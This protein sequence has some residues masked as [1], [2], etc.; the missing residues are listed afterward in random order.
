MQRF[1]RIPDAKYIKM[2]RKNISH[3]LSAN[4]P[5]RVL[6]M[7]NCADGV[8]LAGSYAVGR[9]ISNSDIDIVIFSKN[10]NYIYSESLCEMDYNIQ[11][12]FFPYYKTQYVL[13]KDAFNGKGI[14]ASMFREG[15]II[16]DSPDKILSRMQRYIRNCKERQN[17]CEELALIYRISNALEELNAD[18]SELEKLYIASEI[19][20]NTSKLLTRSY[21]SDSKHNA[22]NIISDKPDTKFIE[23]YRTFVATYDAS[24]FIRDID[25]ILLKF[26]GRQIKYTT[27]WVYT[28]PHSDNLTVFFPSHVLDSQLLECI[29]SIENICQ[30]CYSYVFY[31]G[32]NQA[33]EEGVFLYLF[34]PEK[35]ISEIISQLND[36]RTIN[37]YNHIKQ[38][39]KMTFPYKTIFQEGVLFGGRDHFCS[40]IPYF[41]DI[42]HCFFKLIE[43][44]LN[45]KNHISKI[46]STLLLCELAKVVGISECKKVINELFQILILDAVD[47]NGLYNM[48]QINDL[49]MA[50]LKFYS[51]V[52]EK[53]LSMYKKII[54]GIANREIVEI[55][56]IQNCISQLYNII[57]KIDDE[58]L[59]IP[60]IFNSANKH[61]IL[62]TNTV[63]HL[64]S[65]FQL[66]PTEK[67][68]IVY[69]FSR[70]IQEYDI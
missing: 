68:G 44:S 33:M 42:W 25:S 29:L 14:Y 46:L 66:T 62:W 40:F 15:C 23:S 43:N 3:I 5:P 57:Y 17:E 36:Y 41:C 61:T 19:L 34:T 67:F 45:Q 27:G 52:Y 56:C 16:K 48:L 38:S 50:I 20:L 7:L 51:E 65:I 49:R 9:N 6:N 1:S 60:N 39:I 53:N 2:S 59:A 12:I 64:M 28:F 24:I 69:N 22:R 31:I 18:I 63:E 47:P 32:K 8:I 70:Y 4:I 26:G 54:Q 21:V 37:A 11:L 35:N 55:G 30:G 10:I 13:I 58:V